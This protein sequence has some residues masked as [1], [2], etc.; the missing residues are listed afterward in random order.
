MKWYIQGLVFGYLSVPQRT[1]RLGRGLEMGD[2]HQEHSTR[3]WVA[4]CGSLDRAC[5]CS[6]ELCLELATLLPKTCSCI[7]SDFLQLK[8][9]HYP[10]FSCA[11]FISKFSIFTAHKALYSTSTG[12]WQS[13]PIQQIERRPSNGGFVSC[14]ISPKCSSSLAAQS[15]LVKLTVFS[16]MAFDLSVGD[17]NLPT[18]LRVIRCS[19][20]VL[21][22][23]T[24]HQLLKHLVDEMGTS[25]RNNNPWDAISWKDDGSE[26]FDNNLSITGW[27]G[28]GFNPFGHIVHNKM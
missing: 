8:Q 3:N 18:G 25:I 2:G 20:L 17:F 9:V 6:I 10:S 16:N 24:L 11:A 19:D 12:K 26:Q 23:I 22:S 1:G 7:H 4:S 5:S 27:A 13:F 15:F 21:D 14:S 28:N